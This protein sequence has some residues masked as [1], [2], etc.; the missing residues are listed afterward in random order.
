MCEGVGC[1]TLGHYIL[2]KMDDN[3]GQRILTLCSAAFRFKELK[4]LEAS[5]SK[6]PSVSASWNIERIAWIAAS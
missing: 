5:T 4:A 3:G 1:T 6:H 2:I